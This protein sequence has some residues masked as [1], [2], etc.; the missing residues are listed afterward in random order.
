MKKSVSI[1]VER[2]DIDESYVHTQLTADCTVW[3]KSGNGWVKFVMGG[4]TYWV[5]S[6]ELKKLLRVMKKMK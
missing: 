3:D 5:H 4:E 1:S 6:K 2:E